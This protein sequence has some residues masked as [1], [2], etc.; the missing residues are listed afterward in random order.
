MSISVM[1]DGWHE[2]DEIAANAPDVSMS[3]TSMG[4]VLR[5]AG[6]DGLNPSGDGIPAAR[7]GDALE[8][9]KALEA[10]LAGNEAAE[11]LRIHTL[12]VGSVLAFAQSL[13][14]GAYWA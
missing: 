7:I 11:L 2:N 1:V 3:A 5:A 12:N 10:S 6:Y 4:Q 8:R 9:L 14:R 13:N